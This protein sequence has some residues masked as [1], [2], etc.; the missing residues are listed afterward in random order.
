MNTPRSPIQAINADAAKAR[1]I[2]VV[3]L[4]ILVVSLCIL[5]ACRARMTRPGW[6]VQVDTC[7]DATEHSSPP[8]DPADELD[9]TPA[10]G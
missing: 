6:E 7:D 3:L 2:A 4:A 5:A 10:D 8:A 1:R 9:S